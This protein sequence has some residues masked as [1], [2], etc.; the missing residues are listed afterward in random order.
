MRRTQSWLLMIVF[1][2]GCAIYR[3][4]PI[5]RAAIERALHP[6][7]IGALQIQA[8]EIKHPLLAPVRL[9]P[10]SGLT[11]DQAAVLAVL[12]N[13]AVRATR[14]RRGVAAAELLRAGILPNP[15][16]SGSVDFITGGTIVPGLVTSYGT[17]ASWDLQA[18]IQLGAKK[19]A[20]RADV[21][22]VDLDIAWDEWQIAQAAKLAVYRVVADEAQL[23]RT[24]EVDTR[25][26][27]NLAAV[28][29]ATEAHAQTEVD[30]AT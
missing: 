23:A 29:Q 6:P 16:I 8:N 5:D 30:L 28:R 25:L 21:Q 27:K 13:P 2:S 17:G 12:I 14:D 11:P 26:Q 19:A 20:A 10:R 3:R 22:S 9:T 7:P 24:R 1:F 15:Q 18:L 4:A